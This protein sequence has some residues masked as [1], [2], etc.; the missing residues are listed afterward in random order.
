MSNESGQRRSKKQRKIVEK[1]TDLF[2]KFGVR[3]VT[4]EEI[5]RT[6]NVSKMTFYKY[7]PN[8]MALVKSIWSGW[9]DEGFQ[10]LEEIDVMDIPFPEKLRKLIEY[11]MVLVEKMSQEF[12]DDVL[13][14]DPEM[15]AFAEE[16][17]SR[18]ISLFMEY[19]QRAQDRGDMRRMRPEFIMAVF[20]WM[21]AVVNNDELRGLYPSDTDFIR[22]IQNFFFF[23]MLP[24]RSGGER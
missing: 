3:R 5:C 14:G 11:K 19:I 20:D 12:I 21:R 2:M 8:K 22:E 16:M 1:A 10:R 7:Y 4:V 9:L 24:E 17:R 15:L 13:R 23:G 18:S 6:A